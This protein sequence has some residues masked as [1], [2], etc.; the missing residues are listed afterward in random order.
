[1]ESRSQRRKTPLLQVLPLPLIQLLSP[2]LRSCPCP[3]SFAKINLHLP[4]SVDSVASPVLSTF[5]P[6]QIDTQIL[7]KRSG[8]GAEDAEA[9]RKG[10]G[11]PKKVLQT[12][13]EE[14]V[15]RQAEVPDQF[16]EGETTHQVKLLL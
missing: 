11:K 8:D 10:K 15:L 12:P 7:Q 6:R 14:A 4:P 13:V 9:G 16:R 3:R 1:M 2:R 5:E